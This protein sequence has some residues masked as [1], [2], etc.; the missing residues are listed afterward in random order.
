MDYRKFGD[1]VVARFDRGE[2][3]TGVRFGDR[4][5]KCVYRRSIYGGREKICEKRI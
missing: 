3:F 5:I 1:T 2:E 4:R